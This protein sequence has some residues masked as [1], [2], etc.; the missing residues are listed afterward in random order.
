LNI[1][2]GI[3]KLAR[4]MTSRMAQAYVGVFDSL[5]FTAVVVDIAVFLPENDR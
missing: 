1:L 4:K 3:A 2:T 5:V